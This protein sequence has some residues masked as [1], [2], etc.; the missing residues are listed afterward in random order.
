MIDSQGINWDNA[1]DRSR[2]R[3]DRN[4]RYQSVS[5]VN[6]KIKKKLENCLE[7][8]EFLEF[9]RENLR[10]PH[11]QL[12]NLLHSTSKQDLYYVSSNFVKHYCR[13]NQ[14]T[15]DIFQMTATAMSAKDDIVFAGGFN[16]EYKYSR[17]SDFQ[18][19]TGQVSTST[20]NKIINYVDIQNTRMGKS[21]LIS[22]NDERLRILNLD[23]K[24]I[25]AEFRFPWAV[26][27]RSGF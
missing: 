13:I 21:A 19:Y 6:H 18:E 11:F 1:Q 20:Q 5:L 4:S 8:F 7:I 22:S 10:I 16:G 27:V 14:I 24:K 9:K 2:L 15:T 23:L 17:F 12:N 3:Q 25:L 26:N